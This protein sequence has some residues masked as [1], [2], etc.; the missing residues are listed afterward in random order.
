MQLRPVSILHLGEAVHDVP[1][2]QPELKVLHDACGVVE[3]GSP[4][5]PP[6]WR[7]VGRGAWGRFVVVVVPPPTGGSSSD[8]HACMGTATAATAAAAAAVA[9]AGLRACTD[10]HSRRSRNSM[11]PSSRLVAVAKPSK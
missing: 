6:R 9:A 5:Q 1:A 4:H 2:T 8:R 3:V 11:V 10:R 7:L